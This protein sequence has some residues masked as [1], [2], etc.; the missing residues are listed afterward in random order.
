MRVIRNPENYTT[1]ARAAAVLREIAD[2]TEA[3]TTMVSVYVTLS[4]ATPEEIEAAHERA[5]LKA[6]KQKR[7]E[8]CS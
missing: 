4:V 3:Y 5:R 1:G 2:R 7:A 8:P 6:A